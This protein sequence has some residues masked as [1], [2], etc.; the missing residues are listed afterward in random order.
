MKLVRVSSL[1]REIE[2]PA[3]DDLIDVHIWFAVVK[4]GV[5]EYRLGSSK[6]C[7]LYLGAALGTHR[8][9]K[10]PALQPPP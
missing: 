5:P 10:A 1:Q 6:A 3:N 2:I 7:H 4:T 8:Q 9:R